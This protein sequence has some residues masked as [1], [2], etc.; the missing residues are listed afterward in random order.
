MKNYVKMEF[1]S[2]LSNVTFAR[3][4]LVSFLVDLDLNLHY[5]NEIK[6]IC[7]EAVT[8]AIVHGYGNQAGGR[9]ILTIELLDDDRLIMTIEDFG[10]GIEDIAKAREPLFTT[11]LAEERAGLGF[12]IMDIFSDQLKVYSEVG[13]GTKV[14]IIKL[15]KYNQREN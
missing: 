10:I 12:T 11:K 13:L 15:L 1:D 5:V 6:T 9:V 14:E 2:V 8:N 4:A 7:S 3:G